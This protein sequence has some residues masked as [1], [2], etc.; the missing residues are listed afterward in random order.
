MAKGDVSGRS[1]PPRKGV[2]IALALLL[3]GL[4]LFLFAWPSARLAH[5]SDDGGNLLAGKRPWS[6]NEHVRIAVLTDGEKGREGDGWKSY[7][8]TPL[9]DSSAHV[10]YDLGAE[11][12]IAA[13]W[14]QG[15]NNDSYEVLISSDG[16]EYKSLW[17]A[18]PQRQPGLR[19]RS[20]TSLAGKGR[21]VRLAPHSGDGFF[22]VTELQVFSKVP[23]AFPPAVK[24]IRSSS[25][26]LDL[27]TASTLFGLALLA[28]LFLLHRGS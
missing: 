3:F 18:G 5:A 23:A 27:R 2:R 16:K 22:G 7:A 9:T 6:T 4:G 24:E 14:L 26:D 10:D 13:A 25:L 15:D 12:T 8:T 28:P 1:K 21:Y 19:T 17:I 11:T 20:T